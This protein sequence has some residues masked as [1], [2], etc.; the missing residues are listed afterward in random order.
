MLI[1]RF[2]T[3]LAAA[4][5]LGCGVQAQTRCLQTINTFASNNGG[6]AGGIVYMDIDTKGNNLLLTD[7]HVNTGIGAGTAG[8]G[9]ER[10]RRVRGPAS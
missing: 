10:T 2:S 1:S 9:A 6:S 8:A 4:V 5:A 3:A 7:I